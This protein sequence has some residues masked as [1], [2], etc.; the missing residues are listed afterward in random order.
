MFI[1]LAASGDLDIDGDDPVEMLGLEVPGCM[2]LYA[3]GLVV[4]AS[5]QLVLARLLDVP[6]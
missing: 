4:G 3:P 5:F 2:R 1:E 6:D